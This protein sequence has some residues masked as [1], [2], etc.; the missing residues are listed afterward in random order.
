MQP[1]H[2]RLEL[3]ARAG[4]RQGDVAEMIVDVEVGIAHPHRMVEL[5]RRQRELALEKRDEMQPAFEMIAKGREHVGAL[6]RRPEDREPRDMH[7]RFRRFAVEE[8]GVESRQS[9]H[10]DLH[11]IRAGAG[12]CVRAYTSSHSLRTAALAVSSA[13][14]PSNTMRP[15]PIT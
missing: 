14:V 11:T 6:R 4:L 5:D 2:Q 3:L 1:R 12:T 10:R 13:G 8:A 9:V 15:W 7:R